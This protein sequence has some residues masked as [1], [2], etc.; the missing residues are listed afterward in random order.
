M[1]AND[2]N[3]EAQFATPHRPAPSPT[4]GEGV[5]LCAKQNGICDIASFLRGVAQDF[6]AC[7]RQFCNTNQ[8]LQP[9]KLRI[10]ITLLELLEKDR[11]HV[12]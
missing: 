9:T 8:A 6:A 2:E 4:K 11:Q 1:K 7:S 10:S 3:V 5:T 12:T